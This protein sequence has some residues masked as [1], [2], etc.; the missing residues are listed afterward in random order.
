[1]FSRIQNLA[2]LLHDNYVHVLK[3]KNKIQKIRKERLHSKPTI[4]MT[5]CKIFKSAYLNICKII[6]THILVEI[7][8]WSLKLIAIHV[9]SSLE[10]CEHMPCAGATLFLSS[11]KVR[12][13]VSFSVLLPVVLLSVCVSIRLSVNFSLFHQWAKFHQTWQMHSRVKGIQVHW[14]HQACSKGQLIQRKM[15]WRF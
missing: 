9:C 5:C 10:S 15:H 3:F 4:Q 14:D 7:L 6:F 2:R 1:M 13:Q 8:Q 11:H 12:A